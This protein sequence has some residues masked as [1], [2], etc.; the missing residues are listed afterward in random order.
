M[1]KPYNL[2]WVN[3]SLI[4]LVV[5]I[6]LIT[7]FFMLFLTNL[8][9]DLYPAGDLGGEHYP[10]LVV[11]DALAIRL[12]FSFIG[13]ITGALS[14]GISFWGLCASPTSKFLKVIFTILMITSVIEMSFCGYRYFELQNLSTWLETCEKSIHWRHSRLRSCYLP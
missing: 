8:N 3:T 1:N 5:L 10:Y 7:Y 6:K 12:L 9:R 2:F 4:I 13:F 14:T 11:A